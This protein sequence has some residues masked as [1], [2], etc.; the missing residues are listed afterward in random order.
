MKFYKEISIK[1]VISYSYTGFL[2]YVKRCNRDIYDRISFS[3]ATPSKNPIPREASIQTS[4]FDS[5]QCS[6]MKDVINDKLKQTTVDS[7]QWL[8]SNWYPQNTMRNLAKYNALTPYHLTLDIDIIPSAKMSEAL[9]KFLEDKPTEK[10]ALV[11]PTYEVSKKVK[12]PA[13]KAELVSL[14]RKGQ[15]QPFHKDIFMLNQNATDFAKYVSYCLFFFFNNPGIQLYEYLLLFSK[16]ATLSEYM[17]DCLPSFFFEGA[18]RKI[19]KR[20]FTETR[21]TR[22]GC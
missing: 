20:S 11:I 15:A 3:V 18:R 1:F 21:H 8:L 13:N 7:K 5:M 17:Y 4:D 22:D 14:S 6:T 12:F 2:V 16:S 10:S 19:L 9:N